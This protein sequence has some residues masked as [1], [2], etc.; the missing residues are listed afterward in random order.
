[1]AER[2]VVY[3]C[4]SPDEPRPRSLLSPPAPEIGAIFYDE[5]VA[6]P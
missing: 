3:R 4:S 1:L 5:F 2:V 6:I